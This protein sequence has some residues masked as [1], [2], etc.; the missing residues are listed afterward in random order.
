VIGDF[1]SE[2][3]LRHFFKKVAD[4]AIGAFF[5]KSTR[6]IFL[7]KAASDNLKYLY[8]FVLVE[9]KKNEV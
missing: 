6:I 7:K 4:S 9:N 3:F 5:K 1:S 2:Q 8:C